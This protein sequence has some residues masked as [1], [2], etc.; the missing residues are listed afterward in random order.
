MWPKTEVTVASVFFP[1]FPKILLSDSLVRTRTIIESLAVLPVK[2]FSGDP[3]QEFFAD[4]MTDALIAGLAQIK[5]VKV[6]SRTSVHFTNLL[7]MCGRDKSPS[8]Q[9]PEFQ[10]IRKNLPTVQHSHSCL[11]ARFARC[12]G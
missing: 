5:A 11:P 10:S 9:V 1:R 12:R 6:I 8:W 2:N 4:G 3:A 7:R